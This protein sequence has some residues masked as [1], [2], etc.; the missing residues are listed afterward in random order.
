MKRLRWLTETLLLSLVLLSCVRSTQAVI[1]INERQISEIERP[2]PIDSTDK[3]NIPHRAEVQ[4]FILVRHA[5]KDSK[6]KDPDLSSEGKK[7]AN[8][9][10]EIISEISL[11][12]IYSTRYKRTIQTAQPVAVSQNIKIDHYGGMDHQEVIDQITKNKSLVNILIVGHSNTTPNFLNEL[13]SS[14]DYSNLEENAYS[15]IFIVQKDKS[16]SMTVFHVQST[17]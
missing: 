16:G 8:H 10:A 14:S 3:I 5:E 7:R 1:Q 13:T 12:R 15:D 2:I 6:E 11:D 4:N 9:L 17:Y